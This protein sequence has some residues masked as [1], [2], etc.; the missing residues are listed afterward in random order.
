MTPV[1]VLGDLHHVAP[2]ETPQLLQ[3]VVLW[4][5]EGGEKLCHLPGGVVVD[6]PLVAVDGSHQMS[7]LRIYQ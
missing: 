1:T 6:I 7:H 3:R 4:E 2:R 5:G